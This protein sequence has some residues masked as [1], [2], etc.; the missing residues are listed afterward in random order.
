VFES[1]RRFVQFVSDSFQLFMIKRESKKLES[2]RPK[3]PTRF[4]I[5][6]TIRNSQMGLNRSKL[7]LWGALSAINIGLTIEMVE[8]SSTSQTRVMDIIIAIRCK[9]HQFCFFT[10]NTPTAASNAIQF[11]D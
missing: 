7:S 5:Q 3:Q 6:T 1:W 2:F 11:V 9:T 10:V 8:V 4:V